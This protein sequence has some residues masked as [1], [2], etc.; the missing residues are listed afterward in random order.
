MVEINSGLTGTLRRFYAEW[1]ILF[2][3]LKCLISGQDV[4]RR[5]AIVGMGKPG[6]LLG[7]RWPDR[8]RKRG[9]LDVL[10]TS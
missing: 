7:L 6:C 8:G 4:N 1:K 2:I 5:S 9:E 10:W 3:F